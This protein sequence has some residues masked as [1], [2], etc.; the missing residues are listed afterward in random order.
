MKCRCLQRLAVMILAGVFIAAAA[1]KIADPAGF[2]L[3][4][5]RHHLAPDW[6]I[7]ALGIFLPWLE[8]T[9]AIM[10]FVPRHR[11]GAALMI[12][13]MLLVFTAAIA[14]NI[15]R[16]LDIS[17]GCFSTAPTGAHPIGW[18]NIARNLLLIVLAV[19]VW[20]SGV[21]HEDTKA[22]KKTHQA[23]PPNS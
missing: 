14:I 1:P 22:T 6:A 10:L 16:G 13:L 17:C 4:I 23:S 8:L 12:L 5:Y 2:A 20:K 18:Q 7:N 11:A 15:H 9:A 21:N 3:A 19:I